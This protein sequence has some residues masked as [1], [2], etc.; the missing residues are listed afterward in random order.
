MTCRNHA[1]VS[2]QGFSETCNGTFN[3]ERNQGMYN[4]LSCNLSYCESLLELTSALVANAFYNGELED[5]L[6]QIG[7]IEYC[8]KNDRDGETCMEMIEQQRVRNVYEHPSE[9]CSPDCA[10]RGVP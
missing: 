4:I 1:W 3:L 6:R 9:D 2:F 10:R 8:F 7:R 5:E